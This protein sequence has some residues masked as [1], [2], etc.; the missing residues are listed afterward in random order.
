MKITY[1]I[2]VLNGDFLLRQVLESIYDS[3][4]AICIA[5]G[6]VSYWNSQGVTNSTDDTLK[7]IKEFPDK[8]NKIKL[9][10]GTWKEKTEQCQAWFN[11]VPNDTDYVWCVDS[12]EVHTPENIEKVK[13]YLKDKNPTSLGFKSDSFYGGFERIIGGFE[14]D[15]SFKRILK[16]EKG[17]TYLTHRQPTLELNGNQIQGNDITGN[18]LFK[19]TGVTMWHGSYISP[20]QVYEK[21]QY[22]ETAVISK[23]NC[24]PNY[25]KDVYLEWVNGCDTKRMAIENKW[26]GV[27]EFMPHTRG[28]CFTEKYKGKHPEIIMRDMSELI[29]K[30]DSQLKYYSEI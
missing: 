4:H 30:F 25:F 3:A 23:G 18:Q 16:Y 17:C 14:R 27:Q 10:S 12:D 2:I 29:T 24:I 5:E 13:Q 11:L 6:S 21:I 7:I 15:H 8:E 1:G 20:K 28:A 26:K 19:D 22:Y 9:I